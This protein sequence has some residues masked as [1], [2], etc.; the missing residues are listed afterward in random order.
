MM[1]PSDR[2]PIGVSHFRQPLRP[3]IDLLVLHRGDL[4]ADRVH[5]LL[6]AIA[7][8]DRDRGGLSLG[9]AQIDRLFELGELGVDVLLQGCE[10]VPLRGIVDCQAP[11]PIESR[12]NVLHRRVVWSEITFLFGEQVAALAGF[13]VSDRGKHIVQRRQRVT[14]A[15]NESG[16]LFQCLEIE[17]GDRACRDEKEGGG[18]QA[19]PDQRI[20]ARPQRR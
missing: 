14:A 13:G 19:E 6:T 12:P 2:P 10:A 17:I 4:I 8:Y 16:I 9:L 15:D 18:G 1:P 3:Q 7:L 20:P 5:V 11:Q